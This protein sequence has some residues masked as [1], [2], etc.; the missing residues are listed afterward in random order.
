MIIMYLIGIINLIF[1]L[2]Y[3]HNAQNQITIN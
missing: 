2:K 3:M 1:L